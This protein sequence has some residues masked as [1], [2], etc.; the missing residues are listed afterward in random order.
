MRPGGPSGSTPSP[1]TSAPP[2]PS[3]ESE[4][5]AF[6]RALAAQATPEQMS[7]YLTL[8]RSTRTV[9]GKFED[10]R[11]LLGDASASQELPARKIAFDESLEKVRALLNEYLEGFSGSQKVALREITRKLIH[12]DSRLAER[13]KALDEQIGES[14][15]TRAEFVNSCNNLDDALTS[16]RDE[17]SLLGK[18]M[19]ALP[20]PGDPV[21]ILTTSPVANVVTIGDQAV[22]VTASSTV[23]GTGARSFDGVF[24]LEVIA[25]LGGLQQDITQILRS[26]LVQTDPCGEQISIQRAVVGTSSPAIVVWVQL[27]FERWSCLGSPNSKTPVELMENNGTITLK[28]TPAV[29]KDGSVRIAVDTIGV[30]AN[31][32]LDEMLHSGSLGNLLRERVERSF[33]VALQKGMDLRTMLHMVPLD[34]VTIEAARFVRDSE[35]GTL[36]IALA[37]HLHLSGEQLAGLSSQAPKGESKEKFSKQ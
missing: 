26:Q 18:E 37:G 11:P 13:A 8:V 1:G 27:H 2:Q 5:D 23:F 31:G 24:D 15:T 30:E 25:N 28:V 3:D 6:R 9:L 16:F 33:L 21:R 7:K 4:L 19:Y 20:N 36:G 17:Q 14:K 34:S 10:L 35:D 32:I 12:A 29:E 22:A